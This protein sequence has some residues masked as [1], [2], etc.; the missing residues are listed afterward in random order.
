MKIKEICALTGLTE[1]TIR[2]Y[3]EEKLIS[4]KT[5]HSNG[6]T[7]RDY[8]PDDASRLTVVSQLR[9]AGLSLDEIRTMQRDPKKIAPVMNGFRERLGEEVAERS[10][11]LEAVRDID[12]GSIASLPSLAASLSAGTAGRE[13]PKSD[14]EPDFG[15]FDEEPPEDKADGFERYQKRRQR[16]YAQGRAIVIAVAV[17]NVLLTIASQILGGF[18]F[19]TL[20]VQLILSVC[21][22]M[23]FSWV[24]W[25]FAA[26]SALS[27]A[28]TLYIIAAAGQELSAGYIILLAVLLLFY[29]SSCVLL[30]AHKGVSEFL[31]SQKNG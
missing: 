17:M 5:T 29:A 19:F 21:L 27:A 25:L 30:F 28:M 4:P 11:L 10:A 23:G 15:R 26:G 16:L 31:Y 14:I 6:R 20:V 9:R 8:S 1:R 22:V 3:E 7:Y 24:R 18:S 2:Y 12:F 13:L